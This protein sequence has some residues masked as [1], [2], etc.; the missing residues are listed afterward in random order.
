MSPMPGS[1]PRSRPA[2]STAISSASPR[3]RSASPST[4][5]R[6]LSHAPESRGGAMSALPPCRAAVVGSLLRTQAL[7]DAR[8]RQQAGEISAA[9]LGAV[10][11]QEIRK[12]VAREESIGL[13]AATDGEFRR[14]WWHFDFLEGL[15]G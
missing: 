10:E 5:R 7:K 15:K 11:D 4:I 8:A 3:W 13:Q 6:S 12:I 9:E 1:A 14:A 2:G